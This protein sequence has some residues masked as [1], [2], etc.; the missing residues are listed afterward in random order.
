[1]PSGYF[2]LTGL[3]CA[4]PHGHGGHMYGRKVTEGLQMRTITGTISLMF[5]LKLRQPLK[6]LG[7][8]ALSL[9]SIKLRHCSNNVSPVLSLY[10]EFTL[11][12][13]K[14]RKLCCLWWWSWHPTK[15]VRSFLPF[16][17]LHLKFQFLRGEGELSSALPAG[18]YW[19]LVSR[20]VNLEC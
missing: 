9:L 6:R 5:S 10:L 3:P 11:Q 18:S 19:T 12:K 14:K 15:M 16:H 1:M 20:K 17:L 13:K 8:Q 2:V 4:W 7:L